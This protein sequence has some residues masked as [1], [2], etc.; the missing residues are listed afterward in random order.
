MQAYSLNIFSVFNPYEKVRT[1]KRINFIYHKHKKK[2][3]DN[4]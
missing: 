2:H 3:T 1:T 4:S